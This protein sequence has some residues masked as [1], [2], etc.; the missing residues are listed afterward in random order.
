M[1]SQKCTS[2]ATSQVVFGFRAEGG[3][4]GALGFEVTS[5]LEVLELGNGNVCASMPV[6]SGGRGGMG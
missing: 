6:A 3:V 1:V 5:G 2:W 4:Y